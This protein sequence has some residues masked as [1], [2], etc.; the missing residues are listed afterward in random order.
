MMNGFAKEK[1][2]TNFVSFVLNAPTKML[3][4]NLLFGF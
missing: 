1:S 3:L 2:S 4:M